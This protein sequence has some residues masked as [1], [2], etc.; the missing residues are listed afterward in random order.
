M[1]CKTDITEEFVT[2]D[3]R[4]LSWL[5][6]CKIDITVELGTGDWWSVPQ[7]LN[8]KTYV[9]VEFGTGDWRR[10]PQ[11]LKFKTYITVELVTA[12][13]MGVV[14]HHL[15]SVFAFL[16]SHWAEWSH[17]LFDLFMFHLTEL[18]HWLFALLKCKCYFFNFI[19]FYLHTL[20]VLEEHSRL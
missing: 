20:F 10:V 6:K 13:L 16:G 19:G 17:Q 4:S 9:T 11:S 3:W 1:K 15:Y 7:S 8:F 5:M 14:R 12:V 18:L 2:G